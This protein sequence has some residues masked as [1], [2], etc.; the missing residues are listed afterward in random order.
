M[1]WLFTCHKRYKQQ[2]VDQK[3]AQA[4]IDDIKAKFK[5]TS[6]KTKADVDRLNRLL[7]ANGITLK[8]HIAA[9]GRHG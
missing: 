7:E 8:I 3:D 2:S 5:K 9:G 1:F 4:Q 6:T